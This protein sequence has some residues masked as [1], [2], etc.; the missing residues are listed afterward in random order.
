MERVCRHKHVYSLSFRVLLEPAVNAVLYEIVGYI[1]NTIR[2]GFD[3]WLR[4]ILTLEVLV[5]HYRYEAV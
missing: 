4:H 3:D 1:L 5:H 2:I